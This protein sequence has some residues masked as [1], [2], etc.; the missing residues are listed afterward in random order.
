MKK[1]VLACIISVL[2]TV[3]LLSGCGSSGA[4]SDIITLDFWTI[5]LKA[6]FQDYFEKLIENYEEENPGVH[7]KW[8]DLPYD[9]IRAKLVTAI[10]G[11]NAPDVVNL[12]TQIALTLAGKGTLVDLNSAASVEQ[13]SI[14]TESLWDSAKLGDHVYAF[15][16]YASPDIMFYNK[17]LFDKAGITQP[18]STFDEAISMAKDFKD[19]T[20]AYLFTP[21]EF[22]YQLQEENLPVL[23]EDKTKAAF[24]NQKTV[25]LLDKYKA[26]TDRDILPK[27]GW[28]DWDEELSQFEAGNLAIISSSGSSLNSI[29]SNRPEIAEHMLVAEPL[30]GSTGLS[31]DS[32]MNLVVPADSKHQKEAIDFAAYVT[33]DK[34]QLEFCRQVS[35][36]PSTKKAAADPYFASDTT[37]LEG[38]AS[39]M[40]A[41][42]ANSSK[43]FALGVAEQDDIQDALHNAY[44]AVI[45][46]G[47]DTEDAL[48]D[49]EKVVNDLLEGNVSTSFS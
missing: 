38:Q 27:T 45:V 18:P 19:K 47:D 44:Q 46:N 24:N 4:G 15:P 14:Y 31:R 39:A 26:L 32:L 21:D 16:W 1:K 37:S 36:F 33:N 5:D 17:E 30:K 23:S 43:D 9:D 28:G 22:Y 11:G 7:I 40:S 13:K 34:N 12:N 8:T 20:G 2:L 25:D 6:N 35:I 49:C 3:T 42:A 29:K 41:E 10:A 48:S